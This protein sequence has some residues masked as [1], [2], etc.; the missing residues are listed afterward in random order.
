MNQR[1]FVLHEHP[2]ELAASVFMLGSHA[3]WHPCALE[4]FTR[5]RENVTP[6]YKPCTSSHVALGKWAKVQSPAGL[7]ERRAGTHAP[8]VHPNHHCDSLAA[9]MRPCLPD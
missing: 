4:D 5:N 1:P 7:L 6:R 3:C 8:A 2:C 9:A